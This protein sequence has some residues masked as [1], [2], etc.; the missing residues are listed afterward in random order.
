MVGI[1][2]LQATLG[3]F[4]LPNESSAVVDL[5]INNL[6]LLLGAILMNR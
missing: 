6:I 5:L 3:F 2:L 4:A 1:Y